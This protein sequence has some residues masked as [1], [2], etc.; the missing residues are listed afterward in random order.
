MRQHYTAADMLF[1]Q[2]IILRPPPH[3][4][5]SKLAA[6][7]SMRGAAPAW[8]LPFCIPTKLILPVSRP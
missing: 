8:H 1:P 4:R 6:M 7:P 3:S 5:S 2:G